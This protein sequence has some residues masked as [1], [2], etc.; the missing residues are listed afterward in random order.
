VQTGNIA[1]LKI[2][3][4]SGTDVNTRDKVGFTLLMLAAQGNH[5]DLTKLLL[6]YGADVNAYAPNGWTALERAANRGYIDM[7]IFLLEHGA[8]VQSPFDNA[9]SAIASAAWGGHIEVVKELLVLTT[10]AELEKA[11]FQA[12]Q[13]NHTEICNVL[14]SQMKLDKKRIS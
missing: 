6:E 8:R 13:H 3:L 14:E 2:S 4:S 10:Y 5:E 9:L 1:Q 12:K 11:L 7:V